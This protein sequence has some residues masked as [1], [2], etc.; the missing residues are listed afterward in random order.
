MEHTAN[1]PPA[2]LTINWWALLIGTAYANNR[3]W[4]IPF[5]RLTDVNEQLVRGRE[6][7]Y[8]GWQFATKAV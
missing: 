7:I 5:N 8:F 4:R 3:L 6:G 2:S 1:N